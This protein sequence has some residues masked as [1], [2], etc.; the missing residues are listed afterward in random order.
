MSGT[1]PPLPL[2][3]F[4]AWLQSDSFNIIGLLFIKSLLYYLLINNVSVTTCIEFLKKMT[5]FVIFNI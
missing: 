3:A 2:C 5:E 1:S 4:V